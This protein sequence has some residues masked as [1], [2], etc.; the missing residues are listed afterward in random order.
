[1]CGSL[2]KSWRENF[3][4]F[5]AIPFAAASLGQ[6][7]VAQ[8]HQS[9]SPTQKEERVAV[10]VQFPKVRE[11][12]VNDVGYLKTLL[13]FGQILPPGLFLDK[14]LSV[15]VFYAVLLVEHNITRFIC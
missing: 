11:S 12:I 10:K 8:L 1:M 13:A 6:V 9:I 2:G 15:S 14:T 7:H 5:D 3:S 4:F